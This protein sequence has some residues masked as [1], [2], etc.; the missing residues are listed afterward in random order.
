[1]SLKSESL[2]LTFPAAESMTDIK[3]VY[4]PLV[5]SSKP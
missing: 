2:R 3:T 5:V 4:L 1:M